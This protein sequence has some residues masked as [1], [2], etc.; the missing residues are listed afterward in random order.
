MQPSRST[1]PDTDGRHRAAV[2]PSTGSGAAQLGADRSARH[3][4][5]PPAALRYIVLA[6]AMAVMSV[7]VVLNLPGVSSFGSSDPSP[8]TTAPP[9]TPTEPP[10]ILPTLPPS[11]T[12]AP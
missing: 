3:V 1:A 12:P 6:L 7:V 10:V 5:G 11:D 9:R 2:G 4:Q 8:A